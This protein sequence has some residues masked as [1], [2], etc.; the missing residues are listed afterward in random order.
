MEGEWENQKK[1]GL[2]EGGGRKIT[3]K[4]RENLIHIYPSLVIAKTALDLR[5]MISLADRAALMAQGHTY[6]LGNVTVHAQ[7]STVH[8]N[9]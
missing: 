1:G 5:R 8:T 9:W 6:G 7:Q 2:G 4:R 3:T